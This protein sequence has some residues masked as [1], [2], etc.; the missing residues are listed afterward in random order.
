L[1]LMIVVFRR[2]PLHRWPVTSLAKHARP[3]STAQHHGVL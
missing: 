3:P 2:A 1:A